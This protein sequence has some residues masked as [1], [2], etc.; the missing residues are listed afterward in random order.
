MNLIIKTASKSF[1]IKIN[2]IF[3]NI[4]CFNFIVTFWNYT[5]QMRGLYIFRFLF[6]LTFN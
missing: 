2:N 5:K 6:L 3:E 1:D 4:N